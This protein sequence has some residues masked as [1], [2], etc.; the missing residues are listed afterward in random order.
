MTEPKKRCGCGKAKWPKCACAWWLIMRH[1]GKTWSVSCDVHLEKYEPT[2][3]RP[4]TKGAAETL[5]GEIATAIR[6]GEYP[7]KAAD[8]APAPALDEGLTF[9]AAAAAYVEAVVEVSEVERKTVKQ[10]QSR[11]ARLARTVVPEV[12]CIGTVQIAALTKPVVEA[13]YARTVKGDSN[14]NKSKYRQAL[15]NLLDWAA[16]RGALA[17]NPIPVG[18]RERKKS[19][20]AGKGHMRTRRV[21]A[22]EE[23]N[24]LQAASEARQGDAATRLVTFLVLA[25]DCG[26]RLGEILALR[27]RDVL[28]DEGPLGRLFVA[29]LEEGAR[30][31]G[32]GVSR[33]VP[34]IERPLAVLQHLQTDPNGNPWPGKA[35]VCG[36][37]IGGRVKSVRK[38]WVTAVLRMVNHD[39]VWVTTRKANGKKSNGLDPE[40]QAAFAAVQLH[41]HDIRHERA[42]R[43]LKEG[44]SLGAI[45]KLLGHHDLATLQVYLGMS[46][47]DALREAEG[48]LDVE[49]ETPSGPL[50]VR[51]RTHAGVWVTVDVTQDKRA[52]GVAGRTGAAPN[53]YKTRTKRVQ[54]PHL[55]PLRVVGG[56]EA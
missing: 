42:H 34:L 25:F 29:A 16:E 24:L 11:F 49:D 22:T 45:A 6:N 31:G 20:P 15:V 52:T 18:R 54:N 1:R 26:L 38:S 46:D 4:A 13:L 50:P 40:S 14:S 41:E 51:L 5:V 8:A 47:E 56:K 21:F 2:R 44:R 36:T 55:A 12:G 53:A 43:W 35:Y 39:P 3:E 23:A 33:K 30:K 19:L 27:W 9:T 17:A 28:W 7:P 37:A 32:E 48:T 10:V